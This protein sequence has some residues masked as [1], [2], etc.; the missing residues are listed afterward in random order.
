MNF[1]VAHF[2]MLLL[3]AA[4]SR[5]IVVPLESDEARAAAGTIW[6]LQPVGRYPAWVLKGLI[7][8]RGLSEQFPVECGIA[9]YRVGYW[10][11]GLDG[12][13]TRAT[14]LIAFPTDERLR[15]VVSFQHGTAT[16][17]AMSPSAP[18]PSNGVLA[19]A[20]FASRGYLLVAADYLGLG[21]SPGRHPYLHA[22]SEASAVID[23]LRAARTVVVSNGREWPA[24]T[25]LIGFSQGGHATLS[26]Q[27]ALEA[28]RIDGIYVRASAAIAGPF[29][30]AALSFPF[31]LEGTSTQASTYLGYLLNAYASVY[32]EPLDSTLRDPF[33]EL[34]PN[35]FDGE[36]DGDVVV[37]ALPRLPKE[38]FRDDFLASYSDGS[39][40]WLRERLIENS[41][42]HWSPCAPIR[43]YYGSR[44]TDVS[45]REA[46][47]EAERL[48]QRGGDVVA[49]DVGPYEH[50]ESVLVAVPGIVEWFDSIGLA[51]RQT[52]STEPCR[53]ERAPQ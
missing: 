18:D 22:A 35:L 13:P 9:L 51:R 7:W 45:P 15:G 25:F 47:V 52:G 37:A 27:R 29:D 31:A 34:V 42:T 11:G 33:A 1:R 12:R 6:S 36:H 4:C 30:L 20:A 19:A 24:D 50:D 46:I 41:L 3:I 2:S 26:A 8:W 40:N 49:I 21:E 32:G 43:L 16:H 14:G 44:D 38:M 48:V 17:R 23:L 10:T 39:P 53:N 5:E 28:V